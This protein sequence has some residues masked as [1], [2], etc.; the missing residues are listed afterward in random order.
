MDN[1]AGVSVKLSEFI[2]DDDAIRGAHQT[3]V[4]VAGLGP[5]PTI[6]QQYD[7][8]FHLDFVVTLAE[9]Q[10]STNLHVKNTGLSTSPPI[11]FQALFHNYIRAPANE[12]RVSPLTGLSYYDKTEATEEARA[13]PKVESRQGVDVTKFTDS[14]YEN[15]P[16]RYDVV[17][18]SGAIEIRAT[19]L[20]DVVVWNPQQEAGAKIG[21]METG[22]WYDLIEPG[23][24]AADLANPFTQGEVRLCGTGPCPRI[25]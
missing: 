17:W 2:E 6:Q 20:K 12:V 4:W 1:D 9:H 25:H 11:E 21:D 13:T 10:L 18:P 24:P 15:A 19:N 3:S 7:Y 22:G 16:G 14:V 8:P 5:N 23:F